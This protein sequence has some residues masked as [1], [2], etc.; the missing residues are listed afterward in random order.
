MTAQTLNAQNIFLNGVALTANKWPNHTSGMYYS[1]GVVAIGTNSFSAL[2]DAGNNFKLIVC[3]DIK[4][5]RVVVESGWCDYVF[6]DNYKLRPLSEVEDFIKTN[7]HL[8]DVTA[9]DVIEKDGLEVGKTSAQM[10]KKIEE[11]TLYVI[12]QE[13]SINA[14]KE[15]NQKLESAIN[16]LIEKGGK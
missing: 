5:K 16:S 2:A 12:E 4:T 8:P 6:S 11:L 7:K 10:I 1:T 13:K 9:G 14:L 3:G 15:N